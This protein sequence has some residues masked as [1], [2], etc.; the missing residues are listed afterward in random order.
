VKGDFGFRPL[1]VPSP[2]SPLDSLQ[3][4][5]AAALLRPPRLPR[6]LA[7]LRRASCRAP[8]PSQRRRMVGAP[9]FEPGASALSGQR[10][11]QLSYAPDEMAAGSA[12][13]ME[14][15]VVRSPRRCAAHTTT[16][17]RGR[18]RR[19][20]ALTC[21]GAVTPHPPLSTCVL[22]DYGCVPRLGALRRRDCRAP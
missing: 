14:R 9:G 3:P 4:P 10:S 2:L 15:A 5:A 18:P 1:A 20:Q 11:N 21:P 8:I 13:V 6:R 16:T 17:R 7:A 12:P 19:G 22:A